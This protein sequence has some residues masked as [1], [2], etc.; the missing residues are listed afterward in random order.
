MKKK[1]E[2][3]K[4][5]DG[6]EI[7]AEMAELKKKAMAMISEFQE[8]LGLI[9]GNMG[10]KASM[11]LNL[12]QDQNLLDSDPNLEFRAKKCQADFVAFSAFSSVLDSRTRML[13]SE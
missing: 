2:K 9:V 1:G 10:S 11:L 4:V 7:E 3:T 5:F 6:S 8:N 13:P 12:A